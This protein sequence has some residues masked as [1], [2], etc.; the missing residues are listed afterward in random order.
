MLA[1]VAALLLAIVGEATG[2][3]RD[4]PAVALGILAT[5]A[6]ALS[7]PD[8][9][10]AV[11]AATAGGAF[12]ALV[13]LTPVGGRLGA[14]TGT[15]VLRATAVAGTMAIA[16]TAWIGR[17]L[18]ELA[19]QPMV[20]GLAY[21]AFALAVAIRFGAIPAHAWAARLTDTVPAT[22]LPL[23]TAIAP[24]ALAIIALAWADASIAPLALD[25]SSIQLVVLAVALASIFLASVAAWIQDDIEHVVGYAIV[26]DAGVVILA[27]AAL[28][29]AAWAPAR[30]WI[31][32]L[33]VTR[34]AFAAWAAVAQTP[35]FVVGLIV[36]SLY[37]L[38]AVGLTL[39]Y[40]VAR[41]SHFAQGDAMMVAA[42]L[43]FFLLT[44]A[45]VGSRAGDAVF[46]LHVGALPGAMEPIWRFS[47]GYGL[48]IAIVEAR[49]V[50]RLVG[51]ATRQ[52]FARAGQPAAFL[53][54][55]LGA[56]APFGLP[57]VGASLPASVGRLA[58]ALWA[59]GLV[60]R[61][62]C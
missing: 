37:A 35:Q 30:T 20:F 55:A 49:S 52:P 26:G 62:L 44:G 11:L 32:A 36:G 56:G 57:P 16:A 1:A 51:A 59:S 5:S 18:S 53:N 14:T 54:L 48:V 7:L 4:A 28:D 45:V 31:L 17:D 2:S 24:A 3:R 40:G 50:H 21:L 42:Y 25:L 10:V 15:R 60:D 12:G 13:A 46:P 34:S 6:L 27:I 47:F 19:A 61:H 29:P 39:I 33:I 38:S 41:V 22:A 58:E 43:A 9:R 8:P 23:V